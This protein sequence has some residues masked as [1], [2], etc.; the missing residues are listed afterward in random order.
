MK[1]ERNDQTLT[2]WLDEWLLVYK[3][4]SVSEGTLT[5]YRC[6][7]ALICQFPEAQKRMSEIQ[8][9]DLQRLLNQI[10]SSPPDKKK[11][12]SYSKSI[13][14]KVRI[15]LQQAFRQAYREHLIDS[16]PATDL[17]L[18]IAPTKEIIPLTV[19]QQALVEEV[20]IS[21]PLGHLMLFLLYTGLRREELENLQ[22]CDYD[23]KENTIYIRKSKTP[24]GVRYVYLVHQARE[25]LEAQPRRGIYIFTSTTGGQVTHTV[26][27][28]LYGRI[29]KR[30][31]IE[32]LTNHVCRHTFVT[33]LCEKGVSAKA[34]SQIIGHA[35]SGYVLDIYAKIEQREL[36][37]AIYVLDENVETRSNVVSLKFTE[38]EIIALQKEAKRSGVSVADLIRGFVVHQCCAG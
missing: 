33:R 20:C 28:G 11:A 1:Q 36:R 37:R 10:Q 25:I 26:L 21:D 14:S 6:C 19:E 16:N 9:R 30:T 23:P 22:W 13:L 31:G 15:T 32:A 18:P 35:Q 7:V 29:R 27:R 4:C 38:Q 3:A 12:R 34:I 17:I 8:G 2:E 24:A 5:M